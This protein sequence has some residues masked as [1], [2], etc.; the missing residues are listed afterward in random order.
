MFETCQVRPSGYKF[1]NYYSPD[2]LAEIR[3]DINK[4]PKFDDNFDIRRQLEHFKDEMN[5]SKM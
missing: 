2:G 5:R 4:H 3:K 1:S